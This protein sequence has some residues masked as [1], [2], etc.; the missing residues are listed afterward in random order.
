MF[1]LK[2]TGDPGAT[3]GLVAVDKGV[4]VLNNKHRLTQ[5]KVYATVWDIVEKHDTG[6]TPGG[7]SNNMN[8]FYDAGLVFESS[9]ASGTPYRQGGTQTET[10]NSKIP[11]KDLVPNAPTSTQVSVTGREQ[12]S[13]LVENAISG[14]SMGT[15]I[16]QPG[17]CG[18]QNMIHMTLPVI[19]TTY[20]D[21]T[22]QWEAVGFNKRNEALQH[23]KTDASMTAFCL[24][25]MQETRQLCTETVNVSTLP[26]HCVF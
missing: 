14:N 6:C 4:Y 1:N 11:R 2:V 7:G 20:L 9:T 16:Y 19:A 21:K 3:V 23:I 8:V 13:G 17:G 12:V 25:A 5:K 26:A 15:L 10:L 24:I 22:N 18:E